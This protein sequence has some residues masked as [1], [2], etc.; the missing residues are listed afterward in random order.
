M[1]KVKKAKEQS[2]SVWKNMKTAAGC[3]SF[4]VVSGSDGSACMVPRK[5]NTT[6]DRQFPK[7]FSKHP[8]EIWGVLLYDKRKE[9]FGRKEYGI[10]K[11]T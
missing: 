5:A 7:Y 1:A 10:R 2:S 9:Y 4:A 11:R 6:K 3:R 8:V